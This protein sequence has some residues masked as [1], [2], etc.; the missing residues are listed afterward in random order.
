MGN[1]TI[2]LLDGKKLYY[3]FL[4]GAKNIIEHQKELNKLNFFPVPDADTGTNMAST[5]RSVIERLKP[6]NS[7][8]VTADAIAMAALDGARGN[9]GVIFAQFLYGVSA[10]TSKC[11]N[12]TVE[13]FAESI[14]RS[15]QYIYDAIANPIEGTILTVIREWSEFIYAQ[16]NSITDFVHLLT[17]SLEAAKI[18][19]QSTSKI[20]KNSK[21]PVVDAGA[22]GFVLFLEGII[23]WI[24]SADIRKISEFSREH[25]ITIEESE[26]SED[27]HETF[28]YRFCTEAM[29]KDCSI[30]LKDIRA[31]VENMGD[32]LVIAGSQKLVRLH[33]H[34]D[35][36]QDIF[37]K[38]SA[39]G[40]LTYQKADDMQKQYE[41]AH[42]RKWKIALVTDSACD[43]S[44]EQFDNYQIHIVPIN[45]FFGENHYLD[46]VTLKPDHFY[47][48]L[49][50]YKNLPTTSQ[51][52]EKTF[53]N[54][55]SHLCT[56]YDSVIAVHLSQKFSGTYNSSRLAA[57]KISAEMGKKISVIDS[58][59]LTG[60]LGLLTLR[61]A[62]AIESGMSHDEIVSQANENWRQKSTILVSVKSIKNMIKGGRL[63]PMKGLL[64]KI[65]NLKPIVSG[66]GKGGLMMLDKTFS[67]KSNMHRVISHAKQMLDGKKAWE[68][69]V[70]HAQNIEN[71]EYFLTEMEKITGKKPSALIDTTPIIGLHSGKE[72]LAIAIMEE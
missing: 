9:S 50:K 7:Y 67:Q 56:H 44:P 51:P 38:L 41:S 37:A 39:F 29:M 24:K 66:D 35:K 19:L 5:I 28:N 26:E 58:E 3:S 17:N 40:T 63:S 2:H 32:S 33:I 25:V 4:S 52:N 31:T 30:S 1:T 55:Y 72:A 62:R 61:V 45:I 10:E 57:E 36:P 15:V 20:I 27:L 59:T 49:D 68:Y 43:L 69:Q 48:L 64:A 42:H 16:K 34:T 21:T 13:N 12:I 70:L 23:E 14:N 60:S 53:V 11:E 18:S 65:L 54:L 22:K 47:D 8:K 46:K 71:T 6:H